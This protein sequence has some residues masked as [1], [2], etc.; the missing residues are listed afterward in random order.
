MSGALRFPKTEFLVKNR[1]VLGDKLVV[2]KTPMSPEGII[3][4]KTIFWEGWAWEERL[5]EYIDPDSGALKPG[6]LKSGMWKRVDILATAFNEGPRWYEVPRHH[7]IKGIALINGAEIILKVLTRE[8]CGHEKSV[9][10]RFT[11]T[12][13][14][15]IFA[16][17]TEEAPF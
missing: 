13:P 10:P 4:N 1:M 7:V 6:W 2:R 9:K 11:L 15:R 8:S 3:F 16:P 17:S 12:G 14:Q 5:L